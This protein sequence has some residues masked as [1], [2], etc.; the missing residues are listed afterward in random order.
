MKIGQGKHTSNAMNKG[1]HTR[2]QQLLM[3]VMEFMTE[4]WIGIG[5][6]VSTA[7]TL[8]SEQNSTL[9]QAKQFIIQMDTVGIKL[10]NLL[11]VNRTMMLRLQIKWIS[12]LETT[13]GITPIINF[14]HHFQQTRAYSWVN[15]WIWYS[16]ATDT[17]GNEGTQHEQCYSI[18]T[19]VLP[20]LKYNH[21]I[22]K[23]GYWK[24]RALESAIH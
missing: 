8:D 23:K 16:S 9:T 18:W 3:I 14:Q 19:M 17:S 1:I 7:S 15:C 22:D 13:I 5:N 11:F 12:T 6:E 10:A 2:N 24:L 20:V 21:T 4:S